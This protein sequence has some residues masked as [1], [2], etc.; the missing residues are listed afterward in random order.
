MSQTNPDRA[1]PPDASGLRRETPA[2]HYTARNGSF[3]PS[4]RPIEWILYGVLAALLAVI[5]IYT[6]LLAGWA[7]NGSIIAVLAS[8]LVLSAFGRV[9]PIP[10]LNL[11]QTMASAGGA[12]G[13]AV[14]SFAA[15][16]LADPTFTTNYVTLT[17]MFAALG[18]VGCIIGAS[19]RRYMVR[20]FFP[21]GTACAVIQRTI[22]ERDPLAR[23]RPLR[24][25]TRFGGLAALVTVPAK[26]TFTQGK[27]ALLHAIHIGG[28][29]PI[30]SNLTIGVEPLLYGIGIIV[31]P[32]VGI[33][34][35][36]GGLSAA[37][38]IPE[39]HASSDSLIAAR[40]WSRW[41][42]IALMTLPTFAT[43]LFAYLF[44]H[45]AE[46]PPGFTPGTTSY[47]L[48]RRNIPV[49]GAIALVCV[50]ITSVCAQQIF[51][52]PFYVTIISFVVAFPLCVINGRVTGDTDINPVR[53]VAIIILAGLAWMVNS[54]IAALLGMAVIGG[55]LAGLAVDLMQDQRT[56]H[57]LD[58]NP[59]HQTSILCIGTVIGAI[60]AVPFFA[61]LEARLGFGDGTP[62]P[63]PG[64]KIW[65]QMA[66][67]MAHGLPASAWLPW[68][69]VIVSAVGCIYAF[70]TVWPRTAAYMPSLFGMGIAL[71]LPFEQAGAIF[72]GG[73]IHWGMK[74]AYAYGKQGAEAGAAREKASD[75]SMLIGSSIFAASA[76]V[77]VL[78]ILATELIGKPSGWFYMP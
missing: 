25:L 36:I 11:G 67:V 47:R 37:V 3:L 38:L 17:V 12:V 48:P 60:A 31:G 33:G 52:L 29:G 27:E 34:M 43:I 6:T 68:V 40:E 26:I 59:H 39:L 56:G 23:Q 49:Y 53:L 10:T 65:A 55:T 15:V 74:R 20:Y 22:T 58:C 71:L 24:I 51:A 62:L 9:P 78:V 16:R 28:K 4:L 18:I 72:L 63:A 42:A 66:E 2:E 13:F 41:V 64:P 32:R 73:M 5:N 19:V 7:D 69:I 61:F 75:D 46:V 21:T 70:F 44:K 76:V 1:P 35:L 54:Q 50:G 14:A 8:V 45:Q 57:L 77:A 30:G